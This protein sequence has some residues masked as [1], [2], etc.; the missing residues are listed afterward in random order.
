M[1]KIQVL[2]STMHRARIA[3]LM[4]NDRNIFHNIL[5]VNQTDNENCI[6][7]T[8]SNVRMLNTSTIGTSISRNMALENA[9]GDICIFADDDIIYVPNYEE[10]LQDSFSKYPDADIITFQIITPDGRPFKKNYMTSRRW[11]NQSTVLK[12]A[13]IEIAF[14]RESILKAG[15]KLD[16]EFGLG[17]RYRIHDDVIFLSDAL[18]RGLKILYLPIPIVIH[19]AESSGTMYNDFLLTS[20][21]AAFCR[22]FGR[23]GY[24]IDVV[25]SIK[26]YKEYSKSYSFISFLSL[27]LRGS[28][29]FISSH[30]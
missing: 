17:S 13:S 10:I 29:E 11:H 15:L 9:D 23:I 19:P 2:M 8:D 16:L 20:K 6:V 28:R 22:M 30:K 27:M 4:L 5:I 3:D 26:K 21:G 1:A 25:Y 14:R 7:D 12:C 18:K 24:L